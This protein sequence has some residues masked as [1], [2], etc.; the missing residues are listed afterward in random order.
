MVK[1]CLVVIFFFGSFGVVMAA[2]V[3]NYG[4]AATTALGELSSAVASAL[5]LFGT[6]LAIGV[7]MRM[8]KKFWS[9]TMNGTDT[10]WGK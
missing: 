9:A 3:V 4:A 2:A 6:I 7:G 8:I 1:V 10:G 5:P